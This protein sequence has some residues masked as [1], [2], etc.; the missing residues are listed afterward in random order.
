MPVGGEQAGDLV[1]ASS[2]ARG[3]RGA[4]APGRPPVSC[5]WARAAAPRQ[6]PESPAAGWTNRRSNGPSRRMR[7]LATTLRATPP[8]M[9]RSGRPVRSWSQAAFASRISSSTAWRLRATSWWKRVISASGRARR[10]AEEAREGVRVHP[11]AAH[12]VEV[13]EVE[14]VLPARARG[15]QPAHLVEVA[16]LAVGGE[17]HHLV[18]A[19]VDLEAQVGGERGVEEAQGVGEVDLLEQLDA[20]LPVPG[21]SWWWPTR[22]RRRR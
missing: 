14:P 10:L 22:R 19:V 17:P 3:R 1:R 8:A 15:D 20:P 2:A 12:E 5:A 7:P 4:A 13:V 9:Q 21:R 11:P 16:R 18:L 6:P